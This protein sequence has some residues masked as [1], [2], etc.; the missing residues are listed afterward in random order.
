MSVKHPAPRTAQQHAENAV[1]Y[2]DD[3]ARVMSDAEVPDFR[4]RAFE[5]LSLAVLELGQAVAKIAESRNL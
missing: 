4:D 3:A 5:C 1:D 2:A